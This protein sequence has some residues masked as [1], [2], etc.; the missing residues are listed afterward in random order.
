ML[1]Q[2][3]IAA[4]GAIAFATPL[5]AQEAP[6]TTQVMVLGSYHFSNPGLDAVNLEADDVLSERRQREIQI[7]AE[8]LAEWRPTKI[9]VER[10]VPAPTFLD[11]R[12]ADY[13][14]SLATLRGRTSR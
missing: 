7:L 9:V 1:K 4:I 8:T 13:E 6:P 14:K 3:L 12:Y 11:S 2:M 5:P 10:V